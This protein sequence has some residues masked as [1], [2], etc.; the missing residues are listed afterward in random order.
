MKQENHDSLTSN[1]SN[2][3]IYSP[4]LG[5][6]IFGDNG[7]AIKE[8]DYRKRSN[9]KIY[10]VTNDFIK[11][12]FIKKEAEKILVAIKSDSIILEEP[13]NPPKNNN[14]CP[15]LFYFKFK[16]AR[17]KGH[18]DQQYKEVKKSYSIE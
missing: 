7:N 11:K 10:M 5:E 12:F 14:C 4:T 13:K 2:G 18:E 6:A 9:S 8:E 1:S 3:V 15:C 16:E 17:D